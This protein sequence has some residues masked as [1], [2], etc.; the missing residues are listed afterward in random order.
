MACDLQFGVAL[1]QKQI[2]VIIGRPN[3]FRESV[4]NI[5]WAP[6]HTSLTGRRAALDVHYWPTIW[7]VSDEEVITDQEAPTS[8][9]SVSHDR[10]WPFS[11]IRLCSSVGDDLSAGW[12]MWSWNSTSWQMFMV[13]DFVGLSLSGLLERKLGLAMGTHAIMMIQ[14]YFVLGQSRKCDEWGFLGFRLAP[15][16]TLV[17]YRPI[18]ELLKKHK[19]TIKL[20]VDQNAWGEQLAFSKCI[21]SN[22]HWGVPWFM[23]SQWSIFLI[24]EMD[25]M[26]HW[27]SPWMLVTQ[28]SRP[29]ASN[30]WVNLAW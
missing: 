8:R 7:Y 16:T 22:T 15:W 17:A 25:A 6:I 1:L 4:V 19:W 11:A 3:R 12:S 18:Y 14:S 29:T 28:P 23:D 5:L 2:H 20:A 24:E 13:R 9:R 27:S 10:I 26:I 30:S 21:I